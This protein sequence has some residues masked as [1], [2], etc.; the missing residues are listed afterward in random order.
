MTLSAQISRPS[1]GDLHIVALL[2][3]ERGRRSAMVSSIQC[4]LSVV[5]SMGIIMLFAGIPQLIYSP[6]VTATNVVIFLVGA[7]LLSI[8]VAGN[9]CISYRFRPELNEIVGTLE[10]SG[11]APVDDKPPSYDDLSFLDSAPP[12]Y[13]SVVCDSKS[14][15]NSVS[16]E[17]VPTHAS[18]AGCRNKSSSRESSRDNLWD[19]V[20]AVEVSSGSLSTPNAYSTYPEVLDITQAPGSGATSVLRSQRS[21]HPDIFDVTEVPKRARR[22][23]PPTS[24]SPSAILATPYARSRS[25]V[26]TVSDSLS[27]SRNNCRAVEKPDSTASS[28][29]SERS[30]LYTLK[31][32][33][34]SY[35]LSA[36][37]A[38]ALPPHSCAST[39]FTGT[40]S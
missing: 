37:D 18:T 17:V 2:S 12:D 25:A 30:F 10:E 3:T 16:N 1:D 21:T 36:T 39:S 19:P 26:D 34:C 24:T 28:P 29:D 13:Y 31:G 4:L 35:P 15:T 5:G 27:N 38:P 8:M 11:E 20:F 7:L 6:V 32:R 14:V 40:K 9:A 22:Y 33:D 23:T